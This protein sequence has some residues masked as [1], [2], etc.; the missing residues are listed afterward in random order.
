MIPR[1]QLVVSR[2]TPIL[3]PIIALAYKFG[4]FSR[5]YVRASVFGN[6]FEIGFLV[7]AVDWQ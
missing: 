3:L 4:V 7:S 5:F 6:N 1:R 2:K